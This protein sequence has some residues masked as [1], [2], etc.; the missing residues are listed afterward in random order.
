MFYFYGYFEF[1]FTDE[2]CYLRLTR[3]PPFLV[4]LY[5]RMIISICSSSFYSLMNA[6]SLSKLCCRSLANLLILSLS[7]MVRGELWEIILLISL[8]SNAE[9]KTSDMEF[10]IYLSLSWRIM[11]ASNRLEF[12]DWVC[13]FFMI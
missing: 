8:K 3:L 10:I 1:F 4:I 11:R 12:T 9:D 7:S 2:N 6:A 13:A 5:S